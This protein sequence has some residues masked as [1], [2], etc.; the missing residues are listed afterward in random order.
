ML[1]GVLVGVIVEVKV[2]FED[3]LVVREGIGLEDVDAL[4][5]IEG[6]GLADAEALGEIDAEG[7][8][9]TDADAEALGEIDAKGVAVEL[10]VAVAEG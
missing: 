2:A 1:L 8:G 9:L 4:L 6:A 10:S 3:A 7:A 5:V